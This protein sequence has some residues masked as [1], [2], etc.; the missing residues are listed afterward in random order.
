MKNN[1]KFTYNQDKDDWFFDDEVMDKDEASDGQ[2]EDFTDEDVTAVTQEPDYE[3]VYGSPDDNGKM[4]MGLKVIISTVLV[5]IIVT[6]A[7]IIYRVMPSSK[8]VDLEEFFCTRVIMDGEQLAYSAISED[9]V[10]YIENDFYREHLCDRFYY[11]KETDSMLYTTAQSVCS[12]PVNSNEYVIGGN[13]YTEDYTICIY[14]NDTL[15]IAVDFVKDKAAFDYE[16]YNNPDRIAI[17]TELEPREQV[18]PDKKGVIRDSA[19]RKGKIYETGKDEEKGNWYLVEEQ[20]DYSKVVSADGR[21]G[22]I[23]NDTFSVEQVTPYSSNYEEEVFANQLRDYDIVLAWDAIGNA[24]G[25]KSVAD[26]L[27]GQKGLTTLS[28]T[29]YQVAD[30]EGNIT[31]LADMDY[32]EYVRSR[33]IEIWPLINDFLSVSEN[34]SWDEE[35]LL[36]RSSSRNNLI[37]NI[38]NEIR[39]YGYEGINIDFEKVPATA[40]EHYA[41]FIRELSVRMRAEGKVLSIDNYV[42]KSY[43]RHYARDVQGEFAD[44]VIVMGYDEHYS[45]SEEAGSVA[46]IGFVTEGIDETLKEVPREKLINAMPFYTRLWSQYTD[47]EG[48]EKIT[49]TTCSMDDADR[50]VEE[51]GLVKIWNDECGQYVATGYAD[52]ISYSIW[53][54]EEESIN[55]KM[56]AARQR[57]LAGVAAWRLGFERQDI[58]NII[59]K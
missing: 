9:D 36:S 50:V 48:I 33:G 13:T 7:I 55:I 34:G 41:Q 46:S 3:A 57:Q 26:R 49:A 51:L 17:V 11:D 47:D 24:D 30:A 53:L 14:E 19:S 1:R 42:P 21:R 59:T 2:T 16:I 27:A 40:G 39:T 22:Y 38:I 35:E 29:W 5:V 54:E 44:Y 56:E 43:N 37:D 4:P 10:F 58:W 45:G 23:K 32:V 25:N 20:E 52:G 18:V 12:I 31:S 15:Y 6:I 8:R 28:P